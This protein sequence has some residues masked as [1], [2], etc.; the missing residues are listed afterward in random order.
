LH[1]TLLPD[2]RVLVTAGTSAAGFTNPAGAVFDAEVWD[3]VTG[4]WST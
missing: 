3:P 4:L 2:G 1:S